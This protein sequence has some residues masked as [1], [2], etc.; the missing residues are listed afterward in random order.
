MT[1]DSYQLF[2][3]LDEGHPVRIEVGGEPYTL[4]F[5]GNRTGV[6]NFLLV[7]DRRGQQKRFGW[8]WGSEQVRDALHHLDEG[9]DKPQIPCYRPYDEDAEE[10]GRWVHGH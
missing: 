6:E 7:T 4:Q 2:D 10:Q 5:Q 9:W 3:A 8:G 1:N